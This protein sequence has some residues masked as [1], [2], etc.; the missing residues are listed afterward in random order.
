MSRQAPAQGA[1][2]PRIGLS[3]YVEQ[4]RWGAWDERAVVLTASYVESVA[5][6]GGLPMLLPPILRGELAATAASAIASI[7]GLILT[8][9]SDVDPARYGADPH[10]ETDVPQ[11]HRDDWEI[12]LM[13]AALAVDLPL[14]AICRGVQLLNVARGGTLHQHLPEVLGEVTHRPVRGDYATVAVQVD[15]GSRLAAIVGD[16][17]DVPCHHHQAIDRLGAGVEVCARAEDG[18]VEAVELAGARFA[19]GVQW[20][21]EESGEVALFSALVDAAADGRSA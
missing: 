12:A 21:P 10:E 7:D 8:G 15:A 2:L 18:T 13:Q 9:G 3:T 11:A 5:A 4:V 1:H 19:L 17:S 6:A 20:H 16:R 14:L